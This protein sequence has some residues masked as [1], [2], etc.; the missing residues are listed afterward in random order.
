[1]TTQEAMQRLEAHG[2]EKGREMNARHGASD[3]QFGA[4]RSHIRALAKEIKWDHDLG[5][6][7]WETGNE[8][9]R[10]LATLI[11]RPKQLSAAE[12]DAM[13]KSTGFFQV[14]DWIMTNLVKLSPHKNELREPWM[15]SKAEIV[16][17]AGWSLAAEHVKANPDEAPRML[18]TI[19]KEMKAA[20]F[21]KQE[22]MNYCLVIIGAENPHL[23]ARAIDIAN[24]LEVLK[25]YPVPKGCTSPFAPIW[26]DYLVQRQNPDVLT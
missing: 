22:T 4:N 5:L 13:M 19:E 10:L 15:A 20:P 6:E 25:D 1:M 8:D 26:I 23:R 12:L 3:N 11:M 14:C 18:D 2:T 21:R 24:R 17:R 9:A 7:L 16:G